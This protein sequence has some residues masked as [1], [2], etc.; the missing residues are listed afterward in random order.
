MIVPDYRFVLGSASPRRRQL[1]EELGLKVEV[2]PLHTDESYPQ[3]MP[4][5]MV[6]RFLAEKKARAFS[7]GPSEL[8]ITA[9]T[10]VVA[11]N[12]LLEKA[13]SAAEAKAMLRVL[14]GKVH[15]VI[16][17]VCLKTVTKTVVFDDT[18][19]V[20]FKELSE[21]EMDY[22][23]ANYRPFDKAGAY[24]IQEWIGMVGVVK[25]EGSY[26]NVMGLPVHKLFHHLNVF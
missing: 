9:D 23:I 22:Y 15:Q 24:G 13:R 2:R 12:N 17:G 25:L 14:S 6:A 26:F 3:E 11:G 16:T 7:L 4:R 1:L 5:N 20:T 18:T 8:L 19:H 21:W 10:T